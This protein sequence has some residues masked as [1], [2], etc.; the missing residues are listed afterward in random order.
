MT[1]EPT[2]TLSVSYDERG[3]CLWIGVD[4]LAASRLADG[5]NGRAAPFAIGVDETHTLLSALHAAIDDRDALN[6]RDNP[7]ND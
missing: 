3:L 1:D 2:P 5:P 7:A 4:A 6:I